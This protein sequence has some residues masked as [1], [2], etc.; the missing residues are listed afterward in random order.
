MS[1]ITLH[2]TDAARNMHRYYRLDVQ[3]DL[4]GEWCFVREW[5]RIGRPG[6][7]RSVPYPT[8]QEAH[9]ALARQRRVKERRGYLLQKRG[10]SHLATDK[11]ST[12]DYRCYFSLTGS[13]QNLFQNAL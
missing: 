4:F 10:S 7:M 5:G 8:E 1:A 3:P 9:A 2:R 12:L 6:Q 13:S 11:R